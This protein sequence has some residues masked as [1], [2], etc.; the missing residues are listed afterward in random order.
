M[1]STEMYV[2]QV[3]DVVRGPF[4]GYTAKVLDPVIPEDHLATDETRRKV[5]VE[6]FFS[7]DDTDKVY[8]LPRSLADPNAPAED[9]SATKP[10]EVSTSQ[11]V[12]AFTVIEN[13]STVSPEPITDPM[14]PALDSFRPDPSIVDDYVSRKVPGG[15]KDTDFLL[16]IRSDRDAAGYSPNVALVGETQSGK[17][18]LVRVMAV[19]AARAD[20]MPKPYPV[21]TINGSM[22]VT[23]YDLFGQPAPVMIDG[24]ETLV[25]M[26]GLV[27]RAIQCG[28]ILY[29]DEWNAVPPQQATAIHP[30]LDDR[31]EFVNYQKAVPDGHGGYRPEIVKAH[32]NL[33]VISTINP[34]YKGTQTMAEASTNR[35]RWMSW[36]YD[37]DTEERL[38]PSST[39][40]LVG[41]A[42]RNARFERALTVPVGT[43]A[44]MR[45]NN[46]CA[47][48]GVDTAVWVLEGMFPPSER[49]RVRTILEDRGFIEVL[50]AE[51][52]SPMLN[53]QSSV[54]DNQASTEVN[55]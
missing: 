32:P 18:M 42:L 23:N 10:A 6:I 33:W 9:N 43:S 51:Y 4:A 36:D 35:F 8:I 3:V 55:N 47:V 30:I 54:V 45:F 27:P 52:P 20:G 46:D 5:L 2:G 34:G 7:E 39:V 28:G 50:R 15:M 14:D 40:R 41:D 21:F 16:H 53:S 26:D 12:A 31:R 13:G 37:P 11:Q 29:L 48:Y 22:G 25:W 24:K 1:K 17:T 19:L 38:I 49:S 44:M